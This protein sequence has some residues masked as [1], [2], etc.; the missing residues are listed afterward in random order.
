[1]NGLIHYLE[2]TRIFWAPDNYLGNHS[3][4]YYVVANKTS[5]FIFQPIFGIIRIFKDG[6]LADIPV[7]KGVRT[8]QH[9]RSTLAL[10]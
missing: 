6:V 9:I 4:L 3:C 2:S 1:M 8:M 5:I 7:F 10:I